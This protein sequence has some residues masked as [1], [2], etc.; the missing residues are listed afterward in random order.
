MLQ[1][2]AIY[3]REELANMQKIA[4]ILGKINDNLQIIANFT[5]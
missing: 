3:R 4:D 1:N 5:K 2:P